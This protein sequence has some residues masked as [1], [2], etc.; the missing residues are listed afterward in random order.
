M[1]LLNFNKRWQKVS[2]AAWNWVRLWSR[3]Q[4]VETTFL[5]LGVRLCTSLTLPLR[6]SRA[7]GSP[8]F[9]VSLRI[10]SSE[11]EL[12]H[13]LQTIC[14]V[15]KELDIMWS[16]KVLASMPLVLF[17]RFEEQKKFMWIY[18]PFDKTLAPEIW[19]NQKKQPSC[20]WMW[21]STYYPMWF[22]CLIVMSWI[23]LAR[24]IKTKN[25]QCNLLHLYFI[26]ILVVMRIW[27]CKWK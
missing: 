21:N 22:I 19:R 9:V 25:N 12:K 5:L 17:V 8:F 4:I 26:W 20:P 16:F 24:V 10:D 1:A 6:E 18:L 13:H 23:V 11:S 14:C 7:L 2:I 3:A 15:L 27:T